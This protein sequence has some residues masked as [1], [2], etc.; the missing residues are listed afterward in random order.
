M[1][2]KQ[3][4]FVIFTIK[5]QNDYLVKRSELPNAILTIFTF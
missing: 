2:P 5:L 1:Q 4:I 3:V